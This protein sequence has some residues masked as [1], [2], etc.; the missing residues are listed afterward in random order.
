[1]NRN[2]AVGATAIAPAGGRT[3]QTERDVGDVPIY[4]ARTGQQTRARQI[5]IEAA[6]V[7][8]LVVLLAVMGPF[9]TFH[10]GSWPER[11]AYWARTLLVGYLLFRP[12]LMLAS[13]LARALR[14]PEA[15]GWVAAVLI[16]SAPMTLWLW[17]LGPTIDLDRSW[18][19][20]GHFTETYLQIALIGGLAAAG[21]WWLM[22]SGGENNGCSAIQDSSPPVPEAMSNA[23]PTPLIG[24]RL[25]ERLP[26]HLDDDVIALEMEDHYVRVHTPA[27]STL[28]LMRMGDAVAELS[29]TDG[30]RVHRSWWAARGAVSEVER[31]G[32]TVLLRLVNGLEVPVARGRL[33]GLRAKG[34]L[35]RTAVL[36]SARSAR[37]LR[38]GIQRRS[39]REPLGGSLNLP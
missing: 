9:G 32:R 37:P 12:A 4:E 27:A 31:R 22:G 33:P 6:L 26:P 7:L 14:F 36:V 10:A 24:A 30:L 16:A 2:R 38:R 3:S 25:A 34:W 21:L 20:A 28:V 13:T 15:A 39:V 18:P 8:L 5:M 19:T 1:M 35:D 23:S 29:G 11:L 17:F